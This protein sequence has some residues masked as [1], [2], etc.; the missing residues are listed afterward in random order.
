MVVDKVICSK[1]DPTVFQNAS[2]YLRPVRRNY[3]LI[4]LDG[5]LVITL[6]QV[7][8]RV[9]LFY[10]YQTYQKFLI[11]LTQDFCGY[12][13]GTK[14]ATLI[15]MIMV[16]LA[17]TA[18]FNHTCPYSPGPQ[19]INGYYLDSSKFPKIVPEGQYRLDIKVFEP[20]SNKIIVLVQT[21]MTAK[22]NGP[23]DLGM[24]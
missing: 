11:D 21:Y 7:H 20:K 6:N 18:T 2:C 8:V 23:A 15:D 22:H 5:Y 10:K 3:R 16:G 19:K 1:N 17:K 9:T 13:D 14:S 24:G 12:V 4:D